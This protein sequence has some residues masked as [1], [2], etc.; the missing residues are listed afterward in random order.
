MKGKN[1][2]AEDQLQEAPSFALIFDFGNAGLIEVD[3]AK[4]SVR[5]FCEAKNHD[6]TVLRISANEARAVAT[7]LTAAADRIDLVLTTKR[8]KT[9]AIRSPIGAP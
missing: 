7:G 6:T 9:D 4:D 5:L 8:E 1:N 2:M 3:V